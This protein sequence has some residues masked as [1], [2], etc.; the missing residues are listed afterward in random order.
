MQKT[1]IEWA[2][3]SWNPIK[4]LCP[5]GCWYCYARRMYKR[6]KWDEDLSLQGFNWFPEKPS[7]IFICSTMEIF[8]S[9]IPK[10]WRDYIFKTISLFPQH[11]FIILT[12]LPQNIDREM[13]DNIWLGV[14]VTK[15]KDRWRIEEL[16]NKKARIK[17]VSF[18]P[19]L[20]YLNEPSPFSIFEL[21]WMIIGQLTGYGKK[22][23]PEK[24]WIL[25]MCNPTMRK[26]VKIFLKNNLKN[27]WPGPLIQEFPE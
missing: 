11:T 14:S 24:E 6:F 9:S 27:I 26:H 23:Q 4:G 2:D 3:Y 1:N 25:S 19:L 13:L 18:E 5:V 12:K 17:F 22:Y 21:D 8:H 16:F 7:K 15:N 10:K 20:E